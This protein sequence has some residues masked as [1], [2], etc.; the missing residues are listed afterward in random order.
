MRRIVTGRHDDQAFKRR[1]NDLTERVFG[2]TFT[3]WDALGL[4]DDRYRAYAVEEDGRLLANVSIAQMDLLIGGQRQ[5]AVQLGAVATRPEFRGQGLAR[6]L[7]EHVLDRHAAAPAFLFANDSVL[8]FYPRFGFRRAAEVQPFIQLTAPLRGNPCTRLA[9]DDPLLRRRLESRERYSLVL[10][11]AR[12]AWINLFHLVMEFEQSAY[13]LPAHDTIVIAKQQQDTVLLY[14]VLC[15]PGSSFARAIP[16]LP[17]PGA[18]KLEFAFTPDGLDVAY[19]EQPFVRGDSW[20]HLF[21]RG[22][23]FGAHAKFPY[24]CV[25]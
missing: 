10:D 9:V 6:V 13:F 19:Q 24:L 22:L 25:T 11:V 4:W 14:D 7:M 23:D 21:T 2:F 15:G 5:P 20:G 12:S 1:L 3:K 16:D 18:T 8:D 17:F